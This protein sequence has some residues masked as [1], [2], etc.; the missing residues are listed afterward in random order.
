VRALL[1]LREGVLRAGGGF[2]VTA[3]DTSADVL[4]RGLPTDTDTELDSRPTQGA[5]PQSR[6]R[7]PTTACSKLE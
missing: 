7:R 1:R 6:G 3:A 4:R 2:A 5:R